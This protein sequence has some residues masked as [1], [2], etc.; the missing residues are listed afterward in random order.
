ML[1][2]FFQ[3]RKD[4]KA[5]RAWEQSAL[6]QILLNHSKEYFNKYPRLASFSEEGKNKIIM[7]FYNQI[8]MILQAENPFLAMRESLA[9][10]SIEYARYQIL[11]LTAEE[12]SETFYSEC[13]YISGELYKN[14]DRIV[15]FN[16]ELGELKWKQSDISNDE[17]IEFCNT[18]SLLFLYYLN[19]INYVRSELQDMDKEKDWLRPF[20]K[21]MLI[22]EEDQVREKIGLPRLLPNSLDALKHSSFMNLVIDGYNNPFYEWEKHWAKD[23]IV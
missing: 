1:K 23:E 18:R 12:K 13:P 5:I 6:G 14:I 22:W 3:K 11:C 17:L 16:D 10:Y 21:S 19:G 7:E 4:N 20:I 2:E 8:F 9:S 15:E